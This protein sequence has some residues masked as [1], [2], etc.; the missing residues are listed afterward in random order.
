MSRRA[1]SAPVAVAS[2]NQVGEKSAEE[3]VVLGVMPSAVEDQR[4]A[5][6]TYISGSAAAEGRTFGR[7][8]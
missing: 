4:R 2:E 1:E 8:V 5:R 3:E 6:L 7:T